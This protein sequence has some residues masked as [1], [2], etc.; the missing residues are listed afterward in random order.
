[1]IE[2]ESKEHFEEVISSNDCILVDYFATW[3]G[4]CR[5]MAPM[6]EDVDGPIA[7]LDV[8]ENPELA[9]QYG[10]MG[11]PTLVLF[12]DGEEVDRMTGS[13]RKRDIE[14]FYQC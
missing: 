9:Q 3:C 5:Q 2:I 14:S 4:P 13:Q 11:L 10:V 8:D 6:L 12:K 7:K 1:M